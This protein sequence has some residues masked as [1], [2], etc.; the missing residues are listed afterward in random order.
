[1]V[2]AVHMLAY[3]YRGGE[4][5]RSVVPSGI[6]ASI[7]PDDG[8]EWDNQEVQNLDPQAYLQNLTDE[9][10]EQPTAEDGVDALEN[11]QYHHTVQ[12]V[13]SVLSCVMFDVDNNAFEHGRRRQGASASPSGAPRISAYFTVH[14]E[15]HSRF[16]LRSQIRPSH[17]RLV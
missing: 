6:A 12:Q 1:M 5:A 13:S 16:S 3:R 14:I 7:L 4:T 17:I 11:E 15:S 9:I 8:E 10:H 2:S